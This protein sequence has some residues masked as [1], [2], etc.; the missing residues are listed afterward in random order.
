MEKRVK[1]NIDMPDEIRLIQGLFKSKGFKLFL[2]GGAVRDAFLGLKPKDFDLATDALPDDVEELMKSAGLKTLA[3]GKAFGVINVFT[4]H[5]EFEI[6]TFREDIGS[7]RR[8]ESVIF[9]TIE[10]DV[11]R[12]D[13]TINALFFDLETNEIVDLVGG[14]DDLSKGIIRTVGPAE[15]RF[16]EDRLRILRAI[17]FAARFGSEL[18]EDIINCLQ[19]DSSLSGISSERIR[20]EFI[21]GIKTAKSVRNFIKLLSKF[22]LLGEIFLH[23]MFI[24]NNVGESRDHIIILAIMLRTLGGDSL[25]KLLNDKSFTKDE[26]KGVHFLTRLQVTGDMRVIG[27]KKEQKNSG[28]SKEQIREFARLIGMNGIFIDLFLDFELTVTG[29]QVMEMNGIGP[30]PTVGALVDAMELTNFNKSF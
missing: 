22:N 25:K 2:V 20:D 18:D 17:R 26:V 1:F 15:D 23:D 10:G 16:A 13:L 5:D 28:L 3:T 12:R 14:L 8:P 9:T 24:H 30:G 4:K 7:G 6:A 19:M 29:A 27:M 11:K 21:K